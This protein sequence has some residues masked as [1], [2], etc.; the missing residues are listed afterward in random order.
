MSDLSMQE[1]AKHLR[2]P[3]GSQSILKNVTQGNQWNP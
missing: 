2:K 1:I 3:S